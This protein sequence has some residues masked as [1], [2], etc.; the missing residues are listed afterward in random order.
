MF[1]FLCYFT[2]LLV[3]TSLGI[4]QI[5]AFLLI[6][7]IFCFL[8]FV[9]IP[10][11]HLIHFRGLLLGLV[12]FAF[13]SLSSSFLII[14]AFLKFVRIGSLIAGILH[15]FHLNVDP[16]FLYFGFENLDHLFGFV[17]D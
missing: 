3:L 10:I 13:V 14:Y 4:I 1:Y 9:V 5:Y 2:L 12:L 17:I 16:L 6:K 11:A 8:F 7:F 15:L